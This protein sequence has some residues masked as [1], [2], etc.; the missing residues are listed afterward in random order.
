M[1][2]KTPVIRA[3]QEAALPLEQ[4]IEGR[5]RAEGLDPYRWSNDPGD[6]YPAHTHPLS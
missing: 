4:D 3:W 6:V 1:S 5:L 2:I